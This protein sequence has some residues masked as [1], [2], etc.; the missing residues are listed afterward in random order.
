MHQYPF[1]TA[2]SPQ[3]LTR[4]PSI[5]LPSPSP[6]DSPHAMAGFEMPVGADGEPG[7]PTQMI[8]QAHQVPV[9]ANPA[10]SPEDVMASQV[11]IVSC[12]SALADPSKLWILTCQGDS[13]SSQSPA[14]CP[15]RWHAKHTHTHTPQDLHCLLSL[16]PFCCVFWCLVV[17]CVGVLMVW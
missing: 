3:I 16:T 1:I 7:M 10:M 9:Y 13:L 12:F 5:G 17:E 8:D 15:D 6:Q 2:G 11:R 14:D 4:N